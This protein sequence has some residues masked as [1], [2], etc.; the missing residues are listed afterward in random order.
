VTRSWTD[1]QRT[2]FAVGS[3]QGRWCYGFGRGCHERRGGHCSR[4]EGYQRDLMIC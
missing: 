2:D 3:E 4:E 1:M